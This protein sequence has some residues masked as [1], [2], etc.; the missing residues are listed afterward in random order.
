M[1]WVNGRK[2][3]TR[4]EPCMYVCMPLVIC[5]E[6]TWVV[7]KETILDDRWSKVS[8]TTVAVIVL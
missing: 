2:E 7:G 6:L 3:A 4:E 5:Q 1:A 8:S